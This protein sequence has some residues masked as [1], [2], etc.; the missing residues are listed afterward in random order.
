MI[1]EEWVDGVLKIANSPTL[2]EKYQ[3]DVMFK[4]KVERWHVKQVLEA[5]RLLQDEWLKE[6]N[7]KDTTR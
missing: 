6:M 7:G 5:N 2:M 4:D 3:G 1:S